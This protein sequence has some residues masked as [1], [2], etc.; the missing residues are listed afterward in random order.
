[1]NSV[2]IVFEL[3]ADL[4]ERARA[5]GIE[6]EAQTAPVIEALEAEIRRREAASRLRAT[7]ERLRGLPDDQKPTPDEIDAE[8]K[9]YRAD[10]LRYDSVLAA[11]PVAESSLPVRASESINERET[12]RGISIGSSG[13]H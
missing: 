10:N 4:I 7:T 3:P 5:V 13:I 1:M 12:F 8:I 6:I 11:R 2:P 9:D